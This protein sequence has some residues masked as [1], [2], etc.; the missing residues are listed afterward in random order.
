MFGFSACFAFSGY[1][2]VHTLA[3]GAEGLVWANATNM[4]LRITWSSR[5]IG[6]YF[7]ERGM[8]VGW[9]EVLPSTVAVATAVAVGAAVRGAQVDEERPIRQGGWAVGAA[10]VLL[11]A[12]AGAE[13]GFLRECWGMARAGR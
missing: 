12:V 6:S 9:L 2:F 1:I 10:A 5:F 3:L 7:K 13:R 11:A 4:I 8:P